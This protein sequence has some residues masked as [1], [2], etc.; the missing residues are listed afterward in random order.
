MNNNLY[1]TSI[2]DIRWI[3]YDIPGNIGWGT[4]IIC[5]IRG[6]KQSPIRRSIEAIP[7]IR[8]LIGVAKLISE[9]IAGF[10]RVLTKT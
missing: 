9:C 3:A 7:G 10:D 2:S 5:L 4:Y 6:R 1:K 8:M